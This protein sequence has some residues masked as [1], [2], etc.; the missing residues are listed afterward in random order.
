M[1]KIMIVALAVVLIIVVAG[2][3]IGWTYYANQN[4][5]KNKPAAGISVEQICDR[6]MAY[7]AANYTGTV[8]LMP[9][10][11]WTGGRQD[12]G[13]LGSE[14][15]PYSSGDWCVQI[16]YPV[17][18]NPVYSINVS[19]STQSD[20]VSWTGTYRGTFAETSHAVNITT[21][22]LSTQEQARDTTLVFIQ[23]YHNETTPYMQSITWG[24][25]R[26]TPEGLVG[27]ETYTYQA[28]GNSYWKVTIQYPVVPNPTYSINATYTTASNENVIVWQGT[29]QNGTVT[30]TAYNFNA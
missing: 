19:Y 9:N 23:A 5:D 25:G 27:S 20:T 24:G 14:L 11:P 3:F 15:Y 18:P 26:T 17:V 6:T 29:M 4:Q 13:L 8:Q 7:I 2:G 21:A 30:E 28:A 22:A 16:Q 12:T 1:K 10:A